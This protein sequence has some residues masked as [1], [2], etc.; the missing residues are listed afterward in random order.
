MYISQFQLIPY[1]RVTQQINDTTDIN[2]S[3]GSVYNCNAEA[4]KLLQSF[5]SWLI[6]SQS[7]S[8]VLHADET[9]INIGGKNHWLHSLSN[10]QSTCFHADEKRGSSAMDAIKVLPQFNGVL[11]HDHWTQI[12]MCTCFM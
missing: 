6:K 9:G 12:Q 11:C 2:L 7:N 8:S 5:K 4:Y 1:D 3:T 10:D